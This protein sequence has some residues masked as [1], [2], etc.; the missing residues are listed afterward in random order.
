MKKLIP[1]TDYLHVHDT[2][3]ILYFFEHTDSYVNNMMAYIKAG[4]ERGHHLFVIENNHIYAMAEQKIRTLFSPEQ[5]QC[6]HYVDSSHFYRCY[7]DFHI[8]TILKHFD[9]QVASV[10]KAD[11]TIRS[12]A[13]VEW[14]RLDDIVETLEEYER[15]SDCKVH[16][17]GIMAVCAYAASDISASLLTKMM[18]SHEYLMTDHE[19]VRSSLYRRE[20]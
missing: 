18:R 6:I 17:M 1:L 4:I 8:D 19:F 2:A 3:H 13:H 10:M 15:Q 7:G 14:R 9:E 11:I 12:W 20:S 16:D 5:Q